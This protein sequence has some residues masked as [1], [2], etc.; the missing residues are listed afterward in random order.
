MTMYLK[1]Q[2]GLSMMS[3]D[4]IDALNRRNAD[5]VNDYYALLRISFGVFD[6]LGRICSDGYVSGA[7]LDRARE[8]MRKYQPYLPSDYQSWGFADDL[9]EESDVY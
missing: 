4:Q 7:N 9:A 1:W 2:G 6:V 5:L 8:E 3:S